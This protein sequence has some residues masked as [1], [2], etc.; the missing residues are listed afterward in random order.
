MIILNAYIGKNAYVDK[1]AYICKNSST[2]YRQKCLYREKCPYS[3]AENSWQFGIMPMDFEPISQ[4]MVQ[5][6][7]NAQITTM[8]QNSLSAISQYHAHGPYEF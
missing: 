5:N 1:N 8:V 4:I 3:T 2:Y 6:H 7:H